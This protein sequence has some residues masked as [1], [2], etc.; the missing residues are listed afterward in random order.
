[1]REPNTFLWSFWIVTA[2]LSG[3][4]LRQPLPRRHSCWR[5]GWTR[6]ILLLKHE[7]RS[8]T[9][10]WWCFV[11]DAS[12]LATPGFL[13]SASSGPH[14][15]ST[16]L[17]Y[18]VWFC[19]ILHYAELFLYKLFKSYLCKVWMHTSVF[20]VLWLPTFLV[21]LVGENLTCTSSTQLIH[22]DM[23]PDLAKPAETFQLKACL[24][25]SWEPALHVK[26]LHKHVVHICKL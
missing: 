24:L 26:K 11:L 15:T 14:T 7:L 3:P 19:Y 2:L 5:E 17:T 23:C 25:G 10:W 13:V 22:L 6:E 9:F 21:S 18:F 8:F 12:F 20:I 4:F 1:M 16:V